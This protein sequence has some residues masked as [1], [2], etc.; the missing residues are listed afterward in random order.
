MKAMT[1][2]W[3]YTKGDLEADDTNRFIIF[4]TEEAARTWF[5]QYDPAGIAYEYPVYDMEAVK[6]GK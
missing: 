2:V 3:V 4:E 6:A 5:E 1:S